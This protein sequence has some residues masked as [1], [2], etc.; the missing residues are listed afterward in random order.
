MIN[1]FIRLLIGEEDPRQD[2][3]VRQRCGRISGAVGIA[4]NLLLSALKFF[5]GT[6]TG[7]VAIMA[8]AF[9]NLSD[10]VSSVVTLVGFQ[11]AGRRADDDHPFG[12]GRME[13]LAGL[14][15][16]LLIL[17]VGLELAKTSAGKIIS[18]APVDFSALSA[19]I[20]ALSIGAKLCMWR[21]NRALGRRL[22]SAA[23]QAT[24]TESLADVL[25]TSA[26]LGSGLLSW[27]FGVQ[28]DAWAGLLVAAVILR[29]GWG[30]AK[31]TL[32]PLLG[33]S[34]DPAL[35]R[36]IE[37]TVLSHAEVVG[38]HDLVIHDYGPGR[39][40]MSLHAEV[41]QNCDIMQAHDVI[42]HIE[43]ELR[44]TFGIEN[45]IHMDPIA[46]DDAATNA[47][48]ARVA[49]LVREIDPA[50]SIHDFRMTAGA[51]RQNLIFDVVVPHRF[52]LGDG[53]VCAA[54]TR[55]VAQWEEGCYFAVVEVDHSYTEPPAG[56]LS[57]G[58]GGKPEA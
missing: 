33:Q 50:L 32:D 56:S 44:E 10:A 5:A 17:L 57:G 36:A 35:V 3:A 29:A 7:S 55:G 6:L 14:V 22:Q 38:M 27:R 1:F 13:Y 49:Q 20:L 45:S 24:A 42:D 46:T 16:S 39:R 11:I 54:I 52:H 9:N 12:H 19:G 51:H 34:P 8:D 28:I 26:V 15:V 21:F 40:M 37:K 23:M 48:R 30:A 41:A 47:M 18:P 25:A 58:E 2:P 53:E 4:L 31:S 43:R